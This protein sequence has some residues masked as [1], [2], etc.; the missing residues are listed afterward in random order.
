MRTRPG[1][2]PA[3][4][5]APSARRSGTPLK[6]GGAI[7]LLFACC[8]ISLT[9]PVALGA[10]RE[11]VE[12]DMLAGPSASSINP[13]G[14]TPPPGFTNEQIAYTWNRD[15]PDGEIYLVYANGWT[16]TR[17][18]TAPGAE[19]ELTWSP[20][21]S[22]LAFVRTSGAVSQIHVMNADG[23]QDLNLSN[24]PSS[25]IHPVWSPDGQKILFQ[26]Y[27]SVNFGN[28]VLKDWD[29]YVMSANGSSKTN[30]S[31][32]LLAYDGDVRWSPDGS[33]IVFVSKRD[34][35]SEV[36]RMNAN[37][38]AKLNLTQDVRPDSSP[39]WSPLGTKIA[40][41]RKVGSIMRLHL[42]NTNGTGQVGYPLPDE[43][44]ALADRVRWSPDG[45]KLLVY[46]DTWSDVWTINDDG[47][48]AVILL[49][50]DIRHAGWSA[51]GT[52]VV[53]SSGDGPCAGTDIVVVNATGGGYHDLSPCDNFSADWP[54][55]RPKP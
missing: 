38:S 23:G 21:G 31:Q 45:A 26:R 42:M 4:I 54:A 7:R 14:P 6:P 43:E 28:F 49:G 52:R 12:P 15:N 22:K 19:S 17:L 40:F 11:E 24:G 16:P 46:S 34:G 37:G 9:V 10:C 51:N 1:T 39:D 47:T 35:N 3:M 53:A 30:L 36:Y 20:D 29:V 50:I 18:T 27:A 44:V 13:P 2:W 32:Y 55:W 8:R 33:H 41:V 48:G 25:D 5:L